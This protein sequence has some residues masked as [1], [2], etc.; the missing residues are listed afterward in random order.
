[1]E[2]TEKNKILRDTNVLKIL[3]VIPARSGS[4]GVPNK[5]IKNL[6][7][8]P[9]IEYT[10]DAAKCSKCFDRIIL[11]TDSEEIQSV[12]KKAGVEAPF[13]RPKDL[14]RDCSPLIDA[15]THALLWCEGDKVKY[16]IVYLLQPTSP[17]RNKDHI[18]KALYI[19]IRKKADTLVSVIKV[20]HRFIPSSL[21]YDKN[22]FLKNY[23]GEKVS[24]SR[25]NDD[26][27]WARN[28]PAILITKASLIRKK[29]FYGKKIIGF[30]M[31][32][33]SSIDI[34]THDD[35]KLAERVIHD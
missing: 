5:N 7:E 4:K 17:F 25:H 24:E 16:D 22:G 2:Y 18:A 29:A 8:K 34:D 31:D 20:P 30:P 9:M 21:M 13:L 1:M 14:S 10:I 23:V 26:I 6:G 35:W 32:V 12:A 3:A 19:Y 27:L 15:I 28:G 11:T 33:V